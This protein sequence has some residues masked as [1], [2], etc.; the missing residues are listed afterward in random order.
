MLSDDLGG[1]WRAMY[2]GAVFLRLSEAELVRVLAKT[3]AAALP[4]GLLAWRP[5]DSLG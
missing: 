4:G 2:A 3:A 5:N 1:P